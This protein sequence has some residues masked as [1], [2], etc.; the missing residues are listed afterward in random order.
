MTDAESDK[1]PYNIGVHVTHCCSLH[2][3]KYG[4]DEC[5]VVTGKYLQQYPC[6]Y[7]PDSLKDAQTKIEAAEEG[8]RQ[9]RIERDHLASILARNAS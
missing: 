1:L 3:C 6:E 2:Y 5:P 7:C 4:E 9:A 8:V